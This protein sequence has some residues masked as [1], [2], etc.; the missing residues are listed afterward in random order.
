MPVT[1]LDQSALSRTAVPF[2]RGVLV[3][4]ALHAPWTCSKAIMVFARSRLT[5]RSSRLSSGVASRR[6]LASRSTLRWA[7]PGMPKTRIA[8]VEMQAT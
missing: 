8:L 6:L 1:K 7:L 4:R 3:I 2:H 5:R